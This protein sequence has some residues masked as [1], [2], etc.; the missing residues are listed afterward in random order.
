MSYSI[1]LHGS[2]DIDVDDVMFYDSFYSYESAVDFY[3]DLATDVW[4][5]DD[6]YAIELYNDDTDEIVDYVTRDNPYRE[7]TIASRFTAERLDCALQV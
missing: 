4:E 6:T 1:F 3:N 2:D 7:L 5:D